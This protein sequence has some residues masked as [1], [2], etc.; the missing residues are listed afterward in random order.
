MPIYK[1]DYHFAL[2]LAFFLSWGKALAMPQLTWHAVGRV[3]THYAFIGCMLILLFALI[4]SLRDKP[5]FGRAKSTYFSWGRVVPATL[6]LAAVYALFYILYLPAFSNMQWWT[7]LVL[8]V[9]G[10]VV[11]ILYFYSLVA[12][13]R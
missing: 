12:K 6:V 3:L 8:F 10:W 9:I 7:L 13:P 11:L 2:T 4:A 1:G 5:L